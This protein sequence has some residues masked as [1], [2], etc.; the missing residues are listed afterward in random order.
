MRSAVGPG[1]SR[2]HGA[3]VAGGVVPTFGS[4]AGQGLIGLSVDDLSCVHAAARPVMCALSFA[5]RV[6]KRYV[7]SFRKEP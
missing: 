4:V 5:S 7:R 2:T 3:G 6:H 1:K